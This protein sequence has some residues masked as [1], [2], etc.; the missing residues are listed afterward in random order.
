M[1]KNKKQ[2]DNTTESTST[3]VEVDVHLSIPMKI[4]G[5]VSIR[6]IKLF[7][8]KAAL[9]GFTDD[10]MLYEVSLNASRT[11]SGE[12]FLPMSFDISQSS[13]VTNLR[14]NRVFIG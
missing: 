4:N 3:S 10:D 13:R 11:F 8:E 14:T 7:L 12:D 9:L 5:Y 1:T 6:D 2:T